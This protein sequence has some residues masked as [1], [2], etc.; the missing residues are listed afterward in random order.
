MEAC[1][2]HAGPLL[3][4]PLP[5]R[6]AG[7]AAVIVQA[8][9]LEPPDEVVG[10]T[11]MQPLYQAWEL[12]MH[13]DKRCCTGNE[14]GAQCH[15]MTG[16]VLRSQKSMYLRLCPMDCEYTCCLDC[17]PGLCACGADL[18]MN[19]QL[20]FPQRWGALQHPQ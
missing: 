14:I 4:K 1:G 5:E 13:A 6:L 10:Q 3:Q 16:T 12:N 19:W 7:D 8:L 18:D 17:R 2:K 20:L 15:E 9:S 11:S